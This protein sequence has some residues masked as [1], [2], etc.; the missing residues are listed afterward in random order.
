MSND[1]FIFREETILKKVRVPFGHIKCPK[2]NG[3]GKQ[4]KSYRDPG[5]NEYMSCLNCLGVGYVKELKK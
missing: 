5:P 4:I 3:S 2:C 1:D